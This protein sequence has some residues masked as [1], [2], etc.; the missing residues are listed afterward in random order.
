MSILIPTPQMIHNGL[1]LQPRSTE[2]FGHAFGWAFVMQ[3]TVAA[4]EEY[5]GPRVDLPPTAKIR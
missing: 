5:R 3:E 1:Q 4:A 2:T